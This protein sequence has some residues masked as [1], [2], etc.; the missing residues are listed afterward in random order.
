MSLEHYKEDGSSKGLNE[1][2]RGEKQESSYEGREKLE[3]SSR[4]LFFEREEERRE[5]YEISTREKQEIGRQ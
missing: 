2:L 4:E 1:T 5:C 3:K